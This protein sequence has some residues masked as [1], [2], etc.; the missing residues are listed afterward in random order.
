MAGGACGT[1]PK[2]YW[3]VRLDVCTSQ[4]DDVKPETMACIKAGMLDKWAIY[5][6][7]ADTLGVPQPTVRRVSGILRRR[8]PR[9]SI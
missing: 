3:T 5:E 8:P 6:H 9:C 1:T 7:M 2:F 4:R